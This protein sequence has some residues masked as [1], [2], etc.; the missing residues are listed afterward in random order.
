MILC[1]FCLVSRF[2]SA[3]LGG[4]KWRRQDWQQVKLKEVLDEVQAQARPILAF[5]SQAIATTSCQALRAREN[6]EKAS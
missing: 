2:A 6:G 5:S 3:A 4:T 1:R